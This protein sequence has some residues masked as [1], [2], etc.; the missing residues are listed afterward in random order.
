MGWGGGVGWVINV[1]ADSPKKD[2]EPMHPSSAYG[3]HHHTKRINTK[4]ADL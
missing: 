2:K 3:P 4:M 1:V